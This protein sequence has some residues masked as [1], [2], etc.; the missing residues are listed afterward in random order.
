MRFL[1]LAALLLGH[2]AV[3]QDQPAGPNILFIIS[4]DLSAEALGCYGNEQAHTPHIDAL[5]QRGLLFERAY[6]HFPVCGAARAALL[7]G[8]YPQQNGVTGNADRDI[9]STSL[10]DHPTLPEHFKNEGYTSVRCGKLY[11]MRVPGHITAGIS[12]PDHPASWNEAYNFQSAEQW[13]RGPAEMLSNETLKPDPQR[14]RHYGLGYGTA[15][16]VVEDP[17]DGSEQHDS[18]ATDKAI[19]VL[20]RHRRSRQPL[21]LAVGYV[22]PHVPLVAPATFYEPFDADQLTLPEQIEGDLEDIPPIGR[23]RVG[24]IHGPDTD[25]KARRTLRAYYASVSYMD[26][27]VG[28]LIAALDEQG[29]TGNT[30]IVF[31]SDHGFHLGE[32]GMW[33]KF[34]LHEESARIPLILAGPGIDEGLRS[35]AVTESVDLYPTLC[36]LAGLPIP[37]RCVGLDLTHV[38]EPRDFAYVLHSTGHLIRTADWAYILYRDGSEE[39]YDMVNDPK[40]F[41]NLAKDAGSIEVLDA[42]RVRLKTRLQT[43]GGGT[44]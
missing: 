38:G 31:M 39:L 5:A 34:N 7:S 9:L 3:A 1:I 44:R 22:R 2:V 26:A 29:M 33:Q 28:R 37:E 8:L 21:F 24:S 18:R 11:H 25:Q 10:G 42:M 30:I 40:Q 14:N 19:E 15:F 6:C 12:G 41:T 13:T 35:E 23:G 4:D 27:Q 16:Y 20:K 32:H 36:A 43:M 17:T